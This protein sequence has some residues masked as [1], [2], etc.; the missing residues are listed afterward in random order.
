MTKYEA[1]A[2]AYI[3]SADI[4]SAIVLGGT[5]LTS[6]AAVRTVFSMDASDVI[7]VK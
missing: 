7:T 4:T 2:A 6:D 3:R 5:G 1:T